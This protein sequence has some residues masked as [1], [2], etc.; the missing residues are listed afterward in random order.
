VRLLNPGGYK[1]SSSGPDVLPLVFLPLSFLAF[2]LANFSVSSFL[3]PPSLVCPPAPPKLQAQYRCFFLSFASSFRSYG[4]VSPPT[5][6]CSFYPFLCKTRPR[7]PR[8]L[9]LLLGELMQSQDP[10]DGR[11]APSLIS[12]PSRVGRHDNERLFNNDRRNVPLQNPLRT[13]GPPMLVMSIHPLRAAFYSV[14]PA[15]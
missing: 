3:H 9:L 10:A 15:V 13:D 7:V 4:H 11:L 2:D 1:N 5:N 8:C 12:S 14:P 6:C